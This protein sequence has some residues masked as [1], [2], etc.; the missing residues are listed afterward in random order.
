MWKYIILSNWSI[1]VSS[2]NNN[3]ILSTNACACVYYV[4]MYE[5]EE[6]NGFGDK[7]IPKYTTYLKQGEGVYASEE[8]PILFKRNQPHNGL[9]PD[10]ID[11]KA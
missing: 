2:F 1:K 5:N 8:K 6:E 4:C 11:T 9:F 10:Q 7:I 3:F